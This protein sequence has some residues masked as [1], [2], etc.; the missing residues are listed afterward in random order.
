M[1]DWS[2]KA[3]EKFHTNKENKIIR[4]KKILHDAEIC[5]QQSKDLWDQLTA[6]FAQECTSLNSEPGMTNT[7]SFVRNNGSRGF[8]LS[9]DGTPHKLT[10]EFDPTNSR[11]NFVSST[12]KPARFKIEVRVPEGYSGAVMLAENGASVDFDSFVTDHLDSL[13][14]IA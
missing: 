2:K 6:K 12:W 7:F 9:R 4:D 11:F 8:V 1:S 5:K 13:L 10:G 14:E 3:A